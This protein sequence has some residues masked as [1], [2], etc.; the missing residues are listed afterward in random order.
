MRE[1]SI[2]HTEGPDAVFL[3]VTEPLEDPEEIFFQ[4]LGKVKVVAT[5]SIK[6]LLSKY[7]GVTVIDRKIELPALGLN[8]AFIMIL[9]LNCHSEDIRDI[10]WPV[11]TLSL[12][13]VLQTI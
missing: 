9:L 1:K 8:S 4:P 6:T 3:E 11:Q 12:R 2:R 7:T 5:I 13:P 10:P